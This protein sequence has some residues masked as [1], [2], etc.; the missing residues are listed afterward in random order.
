MFV[1]SIPRAGAVVLGTLR[2]K[3]DESHSLQ[4]L[5]ERNPMIG[6]GWRG[7]APPGHAAGGAA[8]GSSK[9]Q[10]APAKVRCATRSPT[11]RK[12][13][14]APRVLCCRCRSCA[15]SRPHRLAAVTDKRH[16]VTHKESL[17]GKIKSILLGARSGSLSGSLL[18]AVLAHPA[19]PLPGAVPV[20]F[21]AKSRPGLTD[22]DLP[23]QS[24]RPSS[25]SSLSVPAT[26]Y[27]IRTMTH[28]VLLS[29]SVPGAYTL[30]P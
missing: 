9:L 15:R 24:D 1:R 8:A 30:G 25:P 16:G 13:F 2:N 20:R 26:R 3:N 12:P 28:G 21:A 18:L 14:G 4:T 27:P 11:S 5:Y 29:L 19:W 7:G 6:A 10:Q 23:V 17:D 22:P